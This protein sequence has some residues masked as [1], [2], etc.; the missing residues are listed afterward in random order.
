MGRRL[1]LVRNRAILLQYGVYVLIQIIISLSLGILS[2]G[3]SEVIDMI[4]LIQLQFIPYLLLVGG[5]LI[6]LLPVRLLAWVPSFLL[7]PYYLMF[8]LVYVT[9]P[10]WPRMDVAWFFLIGLLW[11]VAI[12]IVV[13]SLFVL[14]NRK[15]KKGSRP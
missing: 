1:N 3:F 9:N 12:P 14:L 8:G 5:L 15:R 6:L 10:K 2:A 7:V 4:V 11:N 13:V